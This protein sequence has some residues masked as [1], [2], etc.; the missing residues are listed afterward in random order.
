MI[1]VKGLSNGFN[2]NK[3]VEKRQLLQ[4]WFQVVDKYY[5]THENCEII[6]SETDLNII[7]QNKDAYDKIKVLSFKKN[8][9]LK[10]FNLKNT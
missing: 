5:F 10:N 6:L 9:R 3:L 1:I 8:I 7:S 4:R 2:L